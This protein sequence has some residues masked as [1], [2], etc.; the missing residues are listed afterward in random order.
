MGR[1]HPN[2]P[3][4]QSVFLIDPC[5]HIGIYSVEWQEKTGKS[6]KI[7]L[8][9]RIWLV[10]L[11]YS[12][13][14]TSRPPRGNTWEQLIDVLPPSCGDQ[15]D[16]QSHNETCISGE[17]D[18]QHEETVIF[19]L[20]VSLSDK[21]QSICLTRSF[22][23]CQAIWHRK[24]EVNQCRDWCLWFRRYIFG[25]FPQWCVSFTFGHH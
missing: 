23:W 19:C 9:K 7:K 17:E 5:L 16:L 25:A 12:D 8:I 21:D 2:H 18:Q 3:G 6:N 11:R 24:Q 4:P 20:V 14:W 22:L 13:T 10:L 1:Q 15:G